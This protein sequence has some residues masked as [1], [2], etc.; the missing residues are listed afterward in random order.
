[1][2]WITRDVYKTALGRS[3][4]GHIRSAFAVCTCDIVM[5]LNLSPYVGSKS[6][7]STAL[8]APCR[9][10]LAHDAQQTPVARTSAQDEMLLAASRVEFYHSKQYREEPILAFD[11]APYATLCITEPPPGPIFE[12]RILRPATMVPI[13]EYDTFS[14]SFR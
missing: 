6:S 1:M 12:A 2:L 13:P 9:A 14:N 10:N 4:Q 8:N 11:S 5:K 7:L 3:G